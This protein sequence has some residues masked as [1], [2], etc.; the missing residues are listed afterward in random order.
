MK[1]LTE[2]EIKIVSTVTSHLMGAVS[3]I[4]LRSSF[5]KNKPLDIAIVMTLITLLY[6]QGLIAMR[7]S[8]KEE[9]DDIQGN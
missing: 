5:F 1:G 4:A 2:K 8:K 6:K 9:V 7:Y 3:K